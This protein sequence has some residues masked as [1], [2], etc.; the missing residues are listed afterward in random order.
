MYWVR[1][2]AESEQQRVPLTLA[3]GLIDAAGR[4]TVS[5]RW[6]D[7]QSE[8]LWMSL[9]FSVAVWLSI[10]LIHFS[11]RVSP[12]QPRLAAPLLRTA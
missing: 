4:W 3:Q 10:S 8:A 5:H 6:T 9:Y 12:G 1:W 2:L 7:W 11:G